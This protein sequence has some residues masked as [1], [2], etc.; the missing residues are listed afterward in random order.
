M[1]INKKISI[2]KIYEAIEGFISSI[3][4]AFTIILD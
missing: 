2:D 4:V 1:R 3:F